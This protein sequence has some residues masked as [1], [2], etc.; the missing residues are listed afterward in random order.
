MST[1]LEYEKIVEHLTN[2]HDGLPSQMFGK[3]CVKIN[4]K[5][6]VALVK[7]FLVFK[8]P[9]NIRSKAISLCG[10]STRGVN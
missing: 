10:Y 7:D 6:G 4:S 8:L 9:E 3:K 2:T 1:E 5:A